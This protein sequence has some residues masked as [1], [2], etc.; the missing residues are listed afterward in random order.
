VSGPAGIVAPR[1]CDLVVSPVSSSG[2]EFM[3]PGLEV[4]SFRG[5]R[6]GGVGHRGRCG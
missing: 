6:C 5:R 2:V 3:L 4:V 1:R